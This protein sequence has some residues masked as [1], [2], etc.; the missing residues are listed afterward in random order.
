MGE[1]AQVQIS[2]GSKSYPK[3]GELNPKSTGVNFAVTFQKFLKPIGKI[4]PKKNK[5]TL[6]LP[7][8]KCT[9]AK[10]TCIFINTVQQDEG[11]FMQL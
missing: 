8:E 4:L 11:I 10:K 2:K 7:W 1:S 6:V 3:F 5:G 9:N